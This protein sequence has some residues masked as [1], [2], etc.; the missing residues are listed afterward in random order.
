MIINYLTLFS[1][2]LIVIILFT[3]SNSKLQTLEL[4]MLQMVKKIELEKLQCLGA[5]D[6]ILKKIE[7]VYEQLEHIAEQYYKDNNNKKVFR[8]LTCSECVRPEVKQIVFRTR[9][10]NSTINIM[11]L[12]KVWIEKQE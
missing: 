7:L 5:D 1:F 2:I 10:A 9:D 12:A 6:N 4:T 8:L 11:K 3:H